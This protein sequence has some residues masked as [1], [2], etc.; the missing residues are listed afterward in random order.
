MH[1]RMNAKS[2]KVKVTFRCVEYH[3]IERDVDEAELQEHNI[4][5]DT[6]AW[7][8]EK[9]RDDTMPD[10]N[11]STES[12]DIDNYDYKLPNDKVSDGGGH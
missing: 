11:I 1:D 7:L 5:G 3:T 6:A 9:F 4:V 10:S 2:V 12:F 8:D